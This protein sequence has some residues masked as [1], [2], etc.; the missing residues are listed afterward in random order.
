MYDDVNGDDLKCTQI[1]VTTQ[2]KKGQLAKKY[3]R[4]VLMNDLCG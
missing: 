3:R 4:T 1:V 2:R